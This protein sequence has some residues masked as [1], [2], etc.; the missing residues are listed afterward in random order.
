MIDDDQEG[1]DL[2]IAL[3]EDGGLHEFVKCA[4][5]LIEPGEFKDNWHIKAICEHL[6]AV[7]RGDIQNLLILV[8]PAC[9]KSLCVSTFW[10]TWEWILKPATK[11]IFSSYGQSLSN[12]NAKQHR[13]LIKS[14][15]FRARWG[16]KVQ[17]SKESLKQIKMFENTAKGF[18]FSTSVGGE[19]TGRHAN[20]LVFDDL[21][22]AQDADG[23]PVITEKDKL[24]KA[25]TFWFKVVGTREANPKTTSRV[26]I[27][28]RLHQ[29]DTA[30]ECIKSGEYETLVLPMEYEPK[31]SCVTCIGFEDPRTEEGELLWPEH[32][33]PE[34]IAKKKDP[35]SGLGPMIYATQCQ[36]NPQQV[37]GN[38]F[39]ETMIQHWREV[40]LPKQWH[41]LIQSW[42]MTFKKTSTSDL[43]CGQVWGL[44]G[45]NFYLLD[46]VMERMRFSEACDAMRA[47]YCKWPDAFEKLVE[48]AANGPAIQ[49]TL[50]DEIPGIVLVKPEGGKESR[51]NAVEAYYASKNIWW[52]PLDIPW[53]PHLKTQHLLF[54]N[55][56]HD[57]GVDAGTQ[58]VLHLAKHSHRNYINALKKL[59]G[60]RAA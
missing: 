1:I 34:Q 50:E 14:D 12:K 2:D 53:V 19:I 58:A 37:G 26:G 7:T 59:K 42:D 30:G 54:P 33:G 20:R 41:M 35:I 9:M 5:S 38:I 6:E 40:S 60:G 39:K 17:L 48:D 13:D 15:W 4:W 23:K 44:H 18:R 31:R 22:K 3:V 51:A 25:N 10:P 16:D 45:A 11:W 27:M 28:Q 29:A 24:Y 46:Q 57:D 8:P 55:A 56:A 21:V 32:H 52:P 36:Q 47:M 49:D 43:V